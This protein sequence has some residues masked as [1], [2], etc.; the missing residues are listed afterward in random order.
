MLVEYETGYAIDKDVDTVVNSAN[1]FLLLG[2]GGAGRIR[3]VS[4]R[5]NPAEK[6]EYDALLGALPKDTGRW[7]TRVYQKNKWHRTYA[8]LSCL[9]ILLNKKDNEFRRGSAVLD[10]GWTATDKR[11]QIH[12]VAM[13]YRLTAEGSVRK[14][15]TKDTI[16]EALRESLKIAESIESRS[17]A[18]PLFC[19]RPS[20]GVTP[21]ESLAAIL[22]VLREFEASSIEKVI[23]CFGKASPPTV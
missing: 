12:A 21:K 19:A 20:Y 18:L 6:V 22:E 9:R 14:K 3:E 23:V 15:A 1:G 7:Y 5:L 4:R 13:S 17:V 16:K 8:Q 10:T 2:T 11:K